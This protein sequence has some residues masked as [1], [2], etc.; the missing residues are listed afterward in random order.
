MRSKAGDALLGGVALGLGLLVAE[1]VESALAA[2]APPNAAALGS[3]TA[4][5]AA[6]PEATPAA[7]LTPLVPERVASYVM[8]ARLDAAAHRVDGTETIRF[9]N[10]SPRA[11]SELYFHLYLNAFKN[12]ASVFLRSPFGEARGNLRAEDWGYID[13]KRCT[14]P[15]LGAADLW[16]AHAPG[17][18]DDPDDETDV[19]LPLPTPLAPGATLELE[20]E[21]SAKLPSIVLRTGYAGNFDF[22]AQWFPKLARLEDDGSFAHFPFHAQAEFYAD[23]GD[24]DVTLDVP[25]NTVVGA[26]GRRVESTPHGDRRVDRYR[27]E[28]VHDFAWAAWPEFH[29]VDRR[30]G[31]V[32]VRVLFPAGHENNVEHTLRALDFALPRASALY[33]A[34]P[35]STLTVVHPPEDAGEA[36]GMEYPTLIATGGPWY[37]GLFGDRGIESVTVHELLHQ[38]FYGLVA[39]NEARSPFLDEGLTSYAELRTLDAMFGAGSA[40]DGFDLAL[41]VTSLERAFAAARA[42][43]LPLSSAAAAFPS[44]RTLGALVYSRTATIL[45]TLARVYGRER[46][47]AALG[48]YART[49]RFAHPT[50]NDLFDTFGRVLGAEARRVLVQA[51]TARGRVDF[52]VREVQNAAERAP[53]GV[54]DRPGGRETVPLARGPAPHYRGR[55]VILRHG[56][57]ELPVDIELVDEAGGRRREHWDGHGPLHVIDYR[58]DSPLAYVVVDPDHKLLLDDDLLDNAAAARTNPCRR[59]LERATYFSE[60]ALGLV[61]P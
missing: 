7:A 8:S 24:Y 52:L 27:A 15:S 45:E 58:G 49:Y 53:A 57:L 39:T 55:A 41:S 30:V 13:V 33:G 1:R 14:A 9:L 23:Y 54:F 5:G 46:L 2:Q 59:T 31:D 20:L 50:P 42:E 19:R 18:P 38:W 34:Y 12:D 47:E 56:E 61:L 6:R 26:V 10:H 32:D 28:G 11:L 22:V 60:L 35:Y 36:G 25:A 37:S 3:G 4:P 43:D 48:E 40:F 29:E 51:L 21:F 17:S 16:P 44:F